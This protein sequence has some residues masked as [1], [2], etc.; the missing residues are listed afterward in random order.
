MSWTP[1]LLALAAALLIGLGFVLQQH[2][3]AQM[4]PSEKLSPRLLL[5][6]LHR[7]IWLVGIGCMV[8]GQILG[9]VALSTGSLALIEPIMAANL[10]FA[11]PIAA[12]WHRCRIS[13]QEWLAALALLAGLAA[14]VGAGDPHGGHAMKA[15]WTSLL[16]AT[17]AVVTVGGGFVYAGRLHP[18]REASLLASAAGV[19]YGLQDALTRRTDV[20]LS[21]DILGAFVSWPVFVLVGVAVVAILINQ[22]A[23]EAGPLPQSL[24]PVTVGEPITGIALGVGVYGEH[25]MTNWTALLVEGGGLVLTI[26][27][28]IFL[29]R[30]E[31]I[32]GPQPAVRGRHARVRAE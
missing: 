16:L 29:A 10:L 27:G 12:V 26:V 5:H 9:A 11:L 25:L 30:S 21:H 3:A 23:F 24:P 4:P 31:L 28:V 1:V 13:R 15:P 20:K 2:A 32:A 14:F 22:S 18:K 6:L 17:G 8:A 7:P 19:G